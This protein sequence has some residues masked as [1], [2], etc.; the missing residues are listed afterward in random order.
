MGFLERVGSFHNR[1]LPILVFGIEVWGC[2]SYSKY[3]SQVDKFLKRSYKYGYL[4][5][6]LSIVD[7][8]N[9]K[10]FYWRK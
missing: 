2:A 6:Q 7:I 8:F 3:L 4:I 9:N 5:H 10:E 1:I